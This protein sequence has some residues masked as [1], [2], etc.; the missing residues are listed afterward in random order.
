MVNIKEVINDAQEALSMD[1]YMDFEEWY[2]AWMIDENGQ[3]INN[4]TMLK[5]LKSI[6]ENAQRELGIK[7]S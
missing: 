6:F 7:G 3:M 5:N 1:R 4:P 2:P